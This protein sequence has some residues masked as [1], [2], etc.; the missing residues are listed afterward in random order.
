MNDFVGYDL[1][2]KLA[3]GAGPEVTNAGGTSIL[4]WESSVIKD[5]QSGSGDD[6]ITGNS[7]AN[8]IYAA[9]GADNISSGGGDDFIN[10]FDGT[11]D[12]VV[13]CGEDLY[14]SSDND[15]V[16]HDLDDQVADNCED[17]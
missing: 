4:N 8:A 7:Y 13:D 2:I 9:N 12:D 3:S 14:G 10:V 15:V 6:Q 16:V 5:V 17:K 11:G 1:T